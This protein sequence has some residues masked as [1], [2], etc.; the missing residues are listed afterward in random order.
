MLEE[1]VHQV[2]AQRPQRYTERG[3]AGR[4]RTPV[5]RSE[6]HEGGERGPVHRGGED[7]KVDGVSVASEC[8]RHEGEVQG[9]DHAQGQELP[10]PE[11]VAVRVLCGAP[12][13]PGDRARDA[14]ADRVLENRVPP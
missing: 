10:D 8:R 1:A 5:E 2:L 4:E 3:R 9:E 6:E 14:A 12:F 11:E 7:Q 13:L